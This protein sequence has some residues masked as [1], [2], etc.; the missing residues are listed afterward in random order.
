MNIFLKEELY[1][2]HTYDISGHDA[3]KIVCLKEE[4]CI[5]H[6]DGHIYKNEKHHLCNKWYHKPTNDKKVSEIH[7]DT[8]VLSLIQKYN[9][10]FQHITFDTLPKIPLIKKLIKN[11]NLVKIMVMNETQRMIQKFG[12]IPQ[13]RFIVRE[14]NRISY[15]SRLLYKFYK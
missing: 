14:N 12:D 4:D 9:K 8:H 6:S 13:E 10:S 11:D 3:D 7:K 1:T 2:K 15:I 5:I